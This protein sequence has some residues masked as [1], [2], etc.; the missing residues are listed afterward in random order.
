MFFSEICVFLECP[1][2]VSENRHNRAILADGIDIHGITADHEI[3]VNHGFV[4]AQSAAL[5]KGLAVMIPNGIGKACAHRQMAGGIFIEQG[6]VEQQ[7]ALADGA[8]LGYQS[9]LSQIGSTLVHGK[10]GVQQFLALFRT[11]AWWNK[12]Y[13]PPDPSWE[14]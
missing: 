2:A 13:P 4:D 1:V 11:R 5:G 12:R 14:R 10:H 6:A 7:T 3:L 8:L 9:A